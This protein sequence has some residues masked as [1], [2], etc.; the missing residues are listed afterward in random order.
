MKPLEKN[1]DS[2]LSLIK[3]GVEEILPERELRK[4]ILGSLET[5]KP[6]KIKAGF[7]PTTP[8]LHIGH[9]ILLQKLRLFQEMGH[10]VHFLIGDYTAMIG[11]P[12]G[13]SETRHPLTAQEVKENAETYQEQVLKIL[14]KNKTRLTFNSEWL[15]KLDLSDLIHLTSKYTIARLLERDDFSKRYKKGSPISMVEFLYPILQGYD[16]VAMQ[17]DIELGGTDQKFNLLVGRDLQV[18]Y[19]QEPQVVITL[20]LLVGTDGVKK[21]SKSLNNYIG[22]QEPAIEIFGKIMSISDTLMW[23]YYDLLADISTEHIEG[24]KRQINEGSMHPKEMKSRLAKELVTRFYDPETV[25]SVAHEWN[26][27]HDPKKRGIPDEIPI[28]KPSKKIMHNGKVGILNAMR[29]SGLVASNSE[30]SR[31]IESN[32]L[33]QLL[34]NKE[35]LITDTR[36]ELGSGEFIFKI[37]KRKFIRIKIP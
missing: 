27:I 25:N 33:K 7:D 28:W 12:T 22:I 4:K 26:R 6:L 2:S 15:K 8:D 34:E 29:E 37:G 11:D 24:L 16:S 31:I 10:E 14:D 13:K 3:K 9:T 23:E 18:A 1:I 21:M 5:N 35:K 32:G 30:A 36:L 19:G 17:A 20:P